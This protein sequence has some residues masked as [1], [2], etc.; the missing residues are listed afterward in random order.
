MAYSL[1]GLQ[2]LGPGG[3]GPRI[4]VYS[5]V[6]PIATVNTSGYFNDASDLL[7]VRDVIL[8]CDTNVPTTNWCNVLSNA[9]GV[10][11]ISDGTAI[12]E[13]DGD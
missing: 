12:A 5:T 11:D 1:D 13:T 2:Q 8:V 10:V 7:A 6:D 9:S 3:A 4:W